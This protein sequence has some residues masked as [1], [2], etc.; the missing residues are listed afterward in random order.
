MTGLQVFARLPEGRIVSIALSP[1]A[2]VKHL[3]EEVQEEAGLQ[4]VPRLLFQNVPLDPSML[5]SET[6][7]TSE[8]TVEADLRSSFKQRIGGGTDHTAAVLDA[9][10][11]ECHWSEQQKSNKDFK[12]MPKDIHTYIQQ[13]FRVEELSAGYSHNILLLV[14]PDGRAVVMCWGRTENG[15]CDVPEELLLGK[16]FVG[17]V[18]AGGR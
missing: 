12:P 6:G 1:E 11:F 5:V 16:L 3:M 2:T 17:Q 7:I 9:G 15:R 13:G 10:R 4:R 8:A 18:S 14:S